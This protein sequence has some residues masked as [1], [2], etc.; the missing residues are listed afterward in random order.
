[1]ITSVRTLWAASEIE[2]VYRNKLNAKDR[3]K[4]HDASTAYNLLMT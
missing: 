2:L 1:M 3:L 4:I